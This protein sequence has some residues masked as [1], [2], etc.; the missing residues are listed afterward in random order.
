MLIPPTVRTIAIEDYDQWL[1]LWNGYN[2]FY[3]SLG[4]NG[5]RA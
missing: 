1:P 5:A 4:T 3:G 2:S